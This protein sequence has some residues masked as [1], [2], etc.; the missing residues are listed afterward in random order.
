MNPEIWVFAPARDRGESKPTLAAI[1][2]ICS[3]REWKVTERRTSEFGSRALVDSVDIRKMYGQIHR[4][5]IGVLSVQAPA[6][7]G[8]QLLARPRRQGVEPRWREAYSLRGLCRHKA[9][10]RRLRWDRDCRSW[11]APFAQWLEHVECEGTSDP[12]CLPLHVFACGRGWSRRLVEAAGR[13][14][15]DDDFGTGAARRDQR[16]RTWEHGQA[17]GR[18]ALHVAGY[19]LPAGFHW[20]RTQ[21]LERCSRRQRPRPRTVCE[22]AFSVRVNCKKPHPSW[23]GLKE[24]ELAGA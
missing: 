18:D 14:A 13:S 7:P 9:F 11:E 19:E 15:F 16:K 21:L 4:S 10:F 22:A 5:R 20:G 6:G 12:R 8:P 17:H 23:R 24:S 3:L 2:R 1:R